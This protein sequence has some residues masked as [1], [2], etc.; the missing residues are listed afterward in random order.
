MRPENHYDLTSGRG[1]DKRA[2][3]GPCT[4]E[5]PGAF[6]P[7]APGT[8]GQAPPGALETRGV[9]Q[10]GARAGSNPNAFFQVKPVPVRLRAGKGKGG[11]PGPGHR[12]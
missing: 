10:D 8:A 6:P 2:G 3:R 4:L 7:P 5:P 9:S 1:T 12:R 11:G